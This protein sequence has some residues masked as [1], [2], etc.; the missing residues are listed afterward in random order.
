MNWFSRLTPVWKL[1]VG[2][3]SFV[4]FVGVLVTINDGWAALRQTAKSIWASFLSFINI[5]LPLWLFCIV[6]L[7]IVGFFIWL[8]RTP[9]AT[10]KRHFK[11]KFRD[12]WIEIE[13]DYANNTRKMVN[14]DV[15]EARCAITGCNRHIVGTDNSYGVRYLRCAGNHFVGGEIKYDVYKKQEEEANAKLEQELREQAL[16]DERRQKEIE[17]AIEKDPSL[18]EKYDNMIG[19]GGVSKVGGY[20]ISDDIQLPRS[21][22]EF[23]NQILD[24]YFQEKKREDFEKIA[25]IGNK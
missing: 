3:G 17:E 14:Q 8:A 25:V 4:S 18:R 7:L 23:Y 20:A 1:I 10:T 5:P 2:I 16:E 21:A 6:A 13:V 15:N 19:H 9:E 22:Q 12:L 24:D 11:E